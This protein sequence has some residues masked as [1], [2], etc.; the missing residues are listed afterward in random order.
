MTSFPAN[1]GVTAD[2]SALQILKLTLLGQESLFSS[3]DKAGQFLGLFIE[4]VA[5]KTTLP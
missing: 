5:G 3:L 2:L 1:D 4:Q